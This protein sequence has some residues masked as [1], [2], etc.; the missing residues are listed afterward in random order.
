MTSLPL[1]QNMI[2]RKPGLANFTDIIKIGITLHTITFKI[3]ITLHTITFKDKLIIKVRRINNSQKKTKLHLVTSPPRHPW[4]TPK[5]PI[6]K[7][8]KKG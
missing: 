7:R 2:L 3:G 5:R 1:F 6:L 4:T 8:V